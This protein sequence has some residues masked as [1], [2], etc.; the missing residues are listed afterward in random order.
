MA[1]IRG[2]GSGLLCLL[3]VGQVAFAQAPSGDIAGPAAQGQS[4]F[5][6]T[7]L[8]LR[9]APPEQQADFATVA[10]SQLAEVYMAEADLAQT[11]AKQTAGA[12]RAKLLGW[13][14]AVNQ[15]ARQL[16]LVI[17]EIELGYPVVLSLGRQ[18]AVSVLVA[19][20]AVI[21][22][23]PRADQQA[24]F[25][26]RV[27][28]GFCVLHDCKKMTAQLAPPEPIPVYAPRY[29]PR[30]TFTESGP[31]CSH[32]GIEVHFG[33]G[34]NLGVLRDICEQLLQ[35]ATELA[36]EIAWQRRHGVILDWS[37]LKLSATPQRPEHLVRLN[38]TG[39]SI[40]LTLPLLFAS[41]GL[42]DDLKPWLRYRASGAESVNLQLD[43]SR[44]GWVPAGS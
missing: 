30:W 8:Y 4:R 28:S 6:R 40:L 15:Y 17:D 3:L 36:T 20:R 19:D 23:H 33:N 16:L 32:D 43:A 29:Q 2:F 24:A 11:E 26:Q 44:Y 14:I 27:L 41:P 9:D 37:L 39:D 13:S 18:G 34:G 35:E 38:A 31:V 10:M 42:V 21:L 7:V 22:G 1:A 25:E 5:D 12:A